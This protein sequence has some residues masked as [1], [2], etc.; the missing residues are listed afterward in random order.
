M[1]WFCAVAEAQE[2]QEQ[3]QA[4]QIADRIE[5]AVLAQIWGRNRYRLAICPGC[6]FR[7]RLPAAAVIAK[8]AD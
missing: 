2:R 3:A 7:L 6:G 1:I 5:I 4:T 8:V